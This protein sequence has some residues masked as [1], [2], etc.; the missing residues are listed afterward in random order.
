M[1][2]A[3]VVTRTRR[4]GSVV[5]ELRGD[6]GLAATAELRHALV[7][8]LLRRRPVRV[9]VDMRRVR[10]VAAEGIGTVVAGREVAADRDVVMVIHR[11]TAMVAGQLRAAGL[12]GACIQHR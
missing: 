5:V 8:A 4:D 6:I 9:V 1:V 3:V 7:S 2:D 12:P 11:P 10:Q